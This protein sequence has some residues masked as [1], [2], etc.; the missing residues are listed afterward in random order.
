MNKEEIIE[1]LEKR[2]VFLARK[3]E[4]KKRVH[5]YDVDEIIIAETEAK[6]EEV[7]TLLK[8]IKGE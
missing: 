1:M 8:R 6:L 2:A 3:L 4:S 7:E 5:F